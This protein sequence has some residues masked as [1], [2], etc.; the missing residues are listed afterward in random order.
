MFRMAKQSI[1]EKVRET[2]LMISISCLETPYGAGD[3][4]VE[5]VFSS[6]QLCFS[7]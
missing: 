4:I 1:V 3:R 5:L 6:L 7:V 2:T